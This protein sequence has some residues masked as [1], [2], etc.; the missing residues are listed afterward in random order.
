MPHLFD[1]P[2]DLVV[3]IQERGRHVICY[4]SAGSWE[5][6]RDDA[7]RFAARA[8]GDTLDGWDDERWLDVTDP[9]RQLRRPLTSARRL[10]R[11]VHLFVYGR[12]SPPAEPPRSSTP[13]STPSTRRS[14]SAT[15]LAFGADP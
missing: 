5:R 4:F 10:W 14:S 13:I 2:P 15:G 9:K 6:W 11:S 1:A 7:D 8:L 3:E 12:E